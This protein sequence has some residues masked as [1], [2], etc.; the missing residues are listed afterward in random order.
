[1]KV[2]KY[3]EPDID[4]LPIEHIITDEQILEQYWDYWSDNMKKLGR[5]NLITKSNCIDDFLIIHWA[6][7]I[8]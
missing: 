8:K 1:M 4:F 6:E 7:E 2:Y 3:V 5:V